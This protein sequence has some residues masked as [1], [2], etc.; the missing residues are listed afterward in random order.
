MKWNDAAKSEGI[1]AVVIALFYQHVK[2]L[3]EKP[4]ENWKTQ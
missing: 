2:V 1:L 3:Q 4:L